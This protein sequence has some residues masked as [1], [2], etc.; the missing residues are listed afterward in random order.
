MA[1]VRASRAEPASTGWLIV[2]LVFAT[3]LWISDVTSMSLYWVARLPI[4]RTPYHSPLALTPA[5]NRNAD[6]Q[7]SPKVRRARKIALSLAIIGALAG[8]F[9]F[10][11]YRARPTYPVWMP[12]TEQERENLSAYFQRNER[13]RR[14]TRD[15][16]RIICHLAWEEYEQGGKREYHPDL[17]KYLAL[18][19]GIA[20]ATFISVFV[21]ALLIPM[22]MRGFGSLARRYLQW[23]NA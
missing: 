9:V 18:N 3:S 15:A 20:A 21:L 16:S 7:R 17:A 13:C 12:L 2:S 19:G 5:A 1:D 4:A 22:M 23:L 10:G 14:E 8:P 6:I 11:S